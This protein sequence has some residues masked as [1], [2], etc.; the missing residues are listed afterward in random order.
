MKTTK[1]NVS[2]KKKV[3]PMKGDN[4]S[5]TAPAPLFGVN[6]TYDQDDLYTTTKAGGLNLEE[7][8]ILLKQ[9]GGS[10]YQIH[11]NP[12]FGRTEGDSYLQSPN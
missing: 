10:G 12:G 3:A 11:L 6:P 7:E 9:F 8:Q 1:K 2:S 5:H 4:V